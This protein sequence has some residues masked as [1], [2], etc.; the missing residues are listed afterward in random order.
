M[1]SAQRGTASA[2]RLGA[3]LGVA[4]LLSACSS[5]GLQWG[6]RSLEWPWPAN[7]ASAPAQAGPRDSF[8]RG[9]VS[10]SLLLPLSGDAATRS[11]AEGLANAMRLAI[12]F[13]ETNPNIGENITITLRD[14]EPPAAAPQLPPRRHWRA[15]A[16]SSSGRSPPIRWWRPAPWRNRPGCLSSALPATPARRGQGFISSRCCP[17]PRCSAAFPTSAARDG[18]GPAGAFPSTPWGEAQATA[19]RK[20]A[21][22]AGFALP[23]V[24]MFS[25][26]GEAVG[27]VAQ[28]QPLIARGQID[29]LFLPDPA[30]APAFGAALAGAGLGPDAVQVVG[31]SAWSGGLIG[32][33]PGLAGAIYPSLDPAGAQAVAGEYQARFGSPPPPGASMAYTAAILA[34][35][36]A[37]SLATPPYPANVLT[38]PSGF[39]GRDGL[40]RLLPDGRS[41][42]A[43]ALMQLGPTGPV[44]LEAA[45]F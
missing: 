34:N 42:H 9:P 21:I 43:L 8:G 12:A 6:S 2:G 16:S 44:V 39:R 40:F 11:T 32:V 15:A 24:Y 45:R 7:G 29:A 30:S 23:S 19:F 22:A 1:R 4:I 28:A 35:V 3:T 41:E 25:S 36:N 5:T 26:P 33:P 17:R 27:I 31:S 37:L 14:S 13:V 18:R 10:V 38:G 20:E